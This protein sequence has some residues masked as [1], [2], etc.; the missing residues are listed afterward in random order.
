[1]FTM[2]QCEV[3][4]MTTLKHVPTYG[5]NDPQTWWVTCSCGSGKNGYLRE[6]WY[7]AH[8]MEAI[9]TE[10]LLRRGRAPLDLAR[11]HAVSVLI[12]CAT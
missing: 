5:G 7:W 10:R 12:T 8:L 11:A 4:K 1:M 6:E 3:Q 2:T 9:V